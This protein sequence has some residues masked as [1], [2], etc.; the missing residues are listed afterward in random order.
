M[1]VT[2]GSNRFLY[3]KLPKA[4]AWVGCRWLVPFPGTWDP[5]P[6]ANLDPGKS[7]GLYKYD[8]NLLSISN[9]RKSCKYEY[10]ETHW[11]HETQ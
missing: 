6:E 1:K 10:H 9:E 4:Q 3:H 7:A 2:E 5:A 8:N 11:Y